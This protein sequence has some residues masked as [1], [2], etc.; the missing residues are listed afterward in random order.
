VWSRR[1]TLLHVVALLLW[2]GWRSVEVLDHEI[3]TVWMLPLPGGYELDVQH[4]RATGAVSVFVQGLDGSDALRV[5]PARAGGS[6]GLGQPDPG[7]VD[8]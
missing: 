3:A 8:R 7:R 2:L 6:A 1:L 5:L 4:M